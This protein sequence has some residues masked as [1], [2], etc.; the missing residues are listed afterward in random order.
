MLIFNPNAGR[1]PPEVAARE[2]ARILRAR[3]WSVSVHATRDAGHVTELARE[4][5]A[6]GMDVLI[7]AGGDGSIGRALPGLIGQHTALAV[8]P[9]GTANVWAQEIGMPR[10]SGPMRG[11]VIKQANLIAG[12]ISAPVDVGI[13]N[14]TPFLLWAG[15]GLDAIVVADAEKHRSH[16][17]KRFAVPEYFVR[18]LTA[19][20]RW[21]GMEIEVKGQRKTGENFDYSGRVQLA[22]VSNIHLYAGGLANISPDARLDDGECD[23]WLFNGRGASTALKH[24]WNLVRGNHVQDP[25]VLRIPFREIRIRT[26]SAVAVHTDG[27]P[28]PEAA[29][30]SISVRTRS[31]Q[32]LL[33]GP[34]SRER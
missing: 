3:G 18:A 2:S 31:L 5:A 34:S 17:K 32:A 8:L 1:Y 19:A 22:V 7:T 27:D 16:L 21:P 14:E 26:G 23:L 25:N 10:I 9:T 24:A 29:E 30:I 33:P 15:I 13:C 28:R 6:S 12:G 20:H 11:D 4:A